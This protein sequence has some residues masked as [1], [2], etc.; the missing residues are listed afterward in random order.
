MRFRGLISVILI[1]LLSFS[2]VYTV[3]AYFP[4]IEDSVYKEDILDL[5]ELG[6]VQGAQDGNFEPFDTLTRAEFCAIL[7]RLNGLNSVVSGKQY[8]T[9]V[10]QE[11]GFFDEIGFAASQGLVKGYPDGNFYPD[12][13]ISYEQANK[14]LVDFLGYGYWAQMRGGYPTGYRI[15]GSTLGLGDGLDLSY[16]MNLNRDELCKLINNALS[17][18]LVEMTGVEGEDSIYKIDE[19]ETILTQYLKL[20]KVTG[21]VD[22]NSFFGLNGTAA[23]DDCIMIDGINYRINDVS[24]NSYVGKNVIATVKIDEGNKINDIVTIKEDESTELTLTHQNYL[25]YDNYTIS[26]D[27]GDGKQKRINISSDVKLIYNGEEKVF[28]KSYINNMAKGTVRLISKNQSRVYDVI[29]ISAY[30]SFVVDSKNEYKQIAYDASKKSS[31]DFSKDITYNIVDSDNKPVTFNEIEIDSVLTYF[32]S[33]KYAEG[34][35][36]NYTVSGTV[37]E[38]GEQDGFS[39]AV[40]NGEQIKLD[41]TTKN[42]ITSYG[43]GSQVKLYLDAF[44]C[45]IHA[46]K[47]AIKTDIIKYLFKLANSSDTALDSTLMG[48]FYDIDNGI[49]ILEFADNVKLNGKLIKNAKASDIKI[50]IPQMVQIKMDEDNK[51]TSVTTATSYGEYMKNPGNDGFCEVFGF[52]DK[53]FFIDSNSFDNKILFDRG[54]AKFMIVPKDMS[55]Y[56]DKHFRT[57]RY[58]YFTNGEEYN[59]AAYNSNKDYEY[60]EVIVCKIEGASQATNVALNHRD[61]LFTVAAKSK[62]IDEDGETCTK[63]TGYIGSEESCFYIDQEDDIVDETLNAEDLEVGDIIF[64]NVNTDNYLKGFKRFYSKTKGF[65]QKITYSSLDSKIVVMDTEAARMT[66]SHIYFRDKASSDPYDYYMIQAKPQ[67]TIV[68]ERNNETFVSAGTLADIEPGDRMIMHICYVQF[69]AVV[70]FKQ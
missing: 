10:P 66:E 61:K 60:C 69:Q 55:N 70:V 25:H 39:C 46:E 31:L 33:S 52:A 62:I 53:T 11:H 20:K 48:K 14:V 36:T 26:Y 3:F 58:S 40:I 63:I 30:T 24:F 8:F 47:A 15:Q 4:D 32:E 49:E 54:T 5:Y 57:E 45:A 13:Y 34:F 2:H 12:A 29:I 44:D 42:A 22:A 28:D 56:E 41:T 59:V 51:V 38:L 68:E 21:F 9:D 27:D 23:D 67:V 64:C 35:V 16:E 17:I 37:S 19:N 50:A 65:E 6:I 7:A 43:I 1:F 18:P